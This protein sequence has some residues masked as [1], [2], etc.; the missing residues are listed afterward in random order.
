MRNA[1]TVI[2]RCGQYVMRDGTTVR[3]NFI[4]S[5][6]NAAYPCHGTY[7]RKRTRIGRWTRNGVF[8]RGASNAAQAPKAGSKLDIVGY[9]GA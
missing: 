3:I 4:D 2:D 1:T 9:V 6:E 7:A 5:R 8:L